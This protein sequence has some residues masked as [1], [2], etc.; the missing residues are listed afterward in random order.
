[1]HV[2]QAPAWGKGPLPD[3]D[4]VRL[5]HD[6][7]ELLSWLRDRLGIEPGGR[8]TRVVSRA[9]LV[10]QPP[11][12]LRGKVAQEGSGTAGRCWDGPLRRERQLRC[13]GLRRPRGHHGRCVASEAVLVDAGGRSLAEVRGE[14]G[15]GE[16]LHVCRGLHARAT[17]QEREGRVS[18]V[19]SWNKLA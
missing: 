13:D 4:L 2:D 15:D 5:Q 12:Q 8:L 18:K 7:R 14:L 10:L 3:Y 16:A 9:P 11:D 17:F 19:G 6:T 1:M